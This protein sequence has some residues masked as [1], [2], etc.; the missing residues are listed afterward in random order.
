MRRDEIGRYM[1]KK[2][3]G[4]VG[5]WYWVCYVSP[6]PRSITAILGSMWDDYVRH[7]GESETCQESPGVAEE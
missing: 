2:A 4:G 3:I 6:V 7:L 5:Y 1:G